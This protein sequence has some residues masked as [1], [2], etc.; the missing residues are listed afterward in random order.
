MIVS[1]AMSI[2]AA[3]P[4]T[5][6]ARSVAASVEVAE[7]ERD[8]SHPRYKDC[9]P[10]KNFSKRI[11]KVTLKKAIKKSGGGIH[12]AKPG[13]LERVNPV[14]GAGVSSINVYSGK[15][16]GFTKYDHDHTFAGIS[17]KLGGE[18][19]YSI[20]ASN[21][22]YS[23]ISKRRALIQL[24]ELYWKQGDQIETISLTEDSE[25]GFCS[26]AGAGKPDTCFSTATA[27]FVIEKD[28]FEALANAD[29]SKPI[30]VT[31]KLLNG[32]MSKCPLYY[33]PL[34]FKAPLT[35]IDAQ[36]EKAEKKR[37]KQIAQGI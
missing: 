6:V 28:T 7:D 10:P 29:L 27:R 11:P 23:T 12:Y 1:L 17:Q 22:N 37:Q 8:P 19:N 26:W 24:A 3:E 20:Y 16:F 33:S 4:T 35:M 9:S 21:T 32:E 13:P 18:K 25:N 14:T 30:V 34:S 36:Y 2:L 15:F 5:K 31:S